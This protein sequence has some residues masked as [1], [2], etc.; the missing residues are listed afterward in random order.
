MIKGIVSS[1]GYWSGYSRAVRDRMLC[2][3]LGS[4]TPGWYD[5]LICYDTPGI[6]RVVLLYLDG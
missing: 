1:Y 2:T 3:C 5:T 6:D 4:C